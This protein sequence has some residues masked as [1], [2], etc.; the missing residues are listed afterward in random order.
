M[1]LHNQG[2][3]HCEKMLW[4]NAAVDD[5]VSSGPEQG[6]GRDIRHTPG[7]HA[8]NGKTQVNAS[9][10]AGAATAEQTSTIAS[11]HRKRGELQHA[12]GH[13]ARFPENLT[14]APVQLPPVPS[15]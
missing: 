14:L 8:G 2:H 10:A 5:A 13:N 6:M 9:S 1:G 7:L 4:S 12:T 3:N 11:P 15:G